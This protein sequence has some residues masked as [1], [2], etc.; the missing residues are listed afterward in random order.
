MLFGGFGKVFSSI[1]GADVISP[2]W[3]CIVSGDGRC[4]QR[5]YST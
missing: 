5:L 1:K 3:Y 4:V 2:A